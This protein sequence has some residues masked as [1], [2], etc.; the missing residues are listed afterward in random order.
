MRRFFL[1]PVVAL[2]AAVLG[3][4]ST[5]AAARPA[6]YQ[7]DFTVPDTT[8]PGI[9]L[10]FHL[11]GGVVD[12]TQNPTKEIVAQPNGIVSWSANG[13]TLSSRGPAVLMIT[14]NA[15][16]S[17]AQTKVAGLLIAVT[18]PGHGVILLDTGYIVFAGEFRAS[19]VILERGPHQF[20]GGEADVTAFCG[21]FAGTL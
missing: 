13:K 2:A 21:Y 11:Q 8:C 16:G 6:I 15:D 12:I 18:V 1:I 17:I 20:L 3:L 19:P 14:Y 10:M 4:A 5:A 7:I 9:D